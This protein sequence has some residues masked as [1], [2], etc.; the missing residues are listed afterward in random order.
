MGKLNI[1]PFSYGLTVLS[2]YDA[3]FVYDPKVLDLTDAD[4]LKSFAEGVQQIAALS[5]EINYPSIAAVPHYFANAYKVC[6]CLMNLDEKQHLLKIPF[7]RTSWPS[8]SLPSTP[9]RDPKRS[10]RFLLTLRPSL[11]PKLLPPLPPLLEDLLL[12]LPLRKKRRR[13]KSQ[14]KRKKRFVFHDFLVDE[15]VFWSCVPCRE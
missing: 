4:L 11:L 12:P 9:S 6:R 13:R 5:L 14:K 10:R 8:L 2:V 7:I 1:R 15:V 3:G